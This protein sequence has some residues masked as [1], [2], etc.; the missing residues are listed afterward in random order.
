MN[1]DQSS[2]AR[3]H[4]LQRDLLEHTLDA[5]TTPFYI[6]DSNWRIVYL[7]QAARESLRG[8]GHADRNH[9]QGMV[10]WEAVP[11]LVGTRFE[12]EYRRAMTTQT[13][14]HFEEYHAPLNSWFRVDVFPTPATMVLQLRDVTREKVRQQYLADA[15]KVLSQTLDYMETLRRLAQLSVPRLADWCTV[16]IA[17]QN[18]ELE[19]VV[20]AHSNPDKVRYARELRRR[21]PPDPESS[22]LYSVFRSG[23]S[24]FAH[25]I[26]DEMLAAGVGDGEYLRM[27]RELGLCSMMTVPLTAHGKTIGVMQFVSAEGRRLYDAADVAF[28]EDLANRAAVAAHNA[29]LFEGAKR[30]EREEA[31]LRKA[32]EAVTASFSVEEIINEIARSALDATEADGSF[33]ERL[34]DDG[35]ELRVVAVAGELHLE[36]NSCIPFEGSLGQ[37]VLEKNQPEL[38]HVLGQSRFP[39]PGVLA[40]MF[41]SSA[42]LA[43]PLVDGGTAI[44]ALILL[45]REGRAPFTEDEAKRAHTFGNLASLAFR[46]VHLLQESE[47][48]RTELEQ[49]IE[50][51]SRLIRGFSHDLKN[52]LGAADGHAS[53]LEDRML[54]ELGE[55]Q[56]SS[57]KRI[58]SAIRA[59]VSLIDDLVELARAEAGQ[60]KLRPHAVDVRE[61]VREMVEQYRPAAEQERL[62]IKGTLE[63]VELI[64][65]DPDRVRQIVGNLLS[66]AVKYTQPG[67]SIEVRTGIRKSDNDLQYPAG[68]VAIDVID[69]GIGIPQD[70]LELLF[71]EFARI[72]PSV[73]PGAGLGLAISRR[74]ARLLGGEITVR[75]ERGT[76]STFTLWLPL[77]QA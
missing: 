12:K 35:K 29:R 30:R 71:T 24:E 58:R 18:G 52:P 74:I 33:V 55:K 16:D 56:L 63:A 70:K 21:Y 6:I 57:V 25:Q 39:L 53:L 64:K 72:D 4:A 17:N 46:K 34:N 9:A 14:V 5:I 7:N 54:G 26:T 23:K 20:V 32:A 62:S 48:R 1:S 11:D 2:P 67:G 60:I 59:A 66:N 77:E 19:Q 43:V 40:Q 15:S 47:T 61:L 45:R 28:A 31:A 76:G 65:S 49:L 75:T 68:C 27:L 51:R 3:S 13:A 42:A 10:L 69:T 41:A 73:K 44:G 50:S 22:G 36:L 8:L 38:V 37:L